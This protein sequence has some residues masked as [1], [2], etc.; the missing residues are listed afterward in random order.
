MMG[1]GYQGSDSLL[2]ELLSVLEKTWS[3]DN[4]TREAA[5]G[6]LAR[7]ESNATPGYLGTLVSIAAQREKVTEAR[8]RRSDHPV[9]TPPLTR[10]ACTLVSR[11]ISD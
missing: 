4:L 3:T 6:A 9:W 8:F 7:L 10:H 11:R 1:E 2:S 5:E